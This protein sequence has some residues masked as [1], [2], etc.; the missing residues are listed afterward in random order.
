MPT[1]AQTSQPI[2]MVCYWNAAVNDNTSACGSD[3]GIFEVEA[4]PA[5]AW[6]SF[7]T[8]TAHFLCLGDHQKVLCRLAVA[9]N[10]AQCPGKAWQYEPAISKGMVRREPTSNLERFRTHTKFNTVNNTL[11]SERIQIR[12]WSPRL[13]LDPRPLKHLTPLSTRLLACT[14]NKPPWTSVSLASGNNI[15]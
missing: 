6:I 4:G 7:R 1:P 8:A 11:S 9:K 15:F 2:T 12:F 10:A 14:L 5:A 13:L 3:A